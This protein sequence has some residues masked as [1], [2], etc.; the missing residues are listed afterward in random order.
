[1]SDLPAPTADDMYVVDSPYEIANWRP[2]AQWVLYI[3]HGLILQALRAVES[4]VFLV[5]WLVFLFTGKLNPGLYG[6]L[7][8]YERYSSRANGFLVGFSETYPGF[9]FTQGPADNGAYPPIRLHLPE[10][11]PVDPPRKAAANILLAIPHYI[12]IA[13]FGIGAVVVAVIAWFAVLFT[14]RWP[15]GMR[16]FL[17]RF[18]NYYYRVWAYV[19]MVRPTEYPRF[20]L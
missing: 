19:S 12:V 3:P 9:D 2:L 8:M 10:L 1:M 4:V 11:P 7:G 15:E 14:G 20:G 13:V 6:F 16:D 5:Y 18:A 17:V